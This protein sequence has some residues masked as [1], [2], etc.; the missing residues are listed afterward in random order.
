MSPRPRDV[1]TPEQI[2]TATMRR[3]QETPG[4]MHPE[5]AAKQLLADL[6]GHR[7]ELV[8][9]PAAPDPCQL[10]PATKLTA[11]GYCPICGP[12]D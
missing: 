2:L 10:H 6:A 9:R 1:L 4:P 5:L 11:H 12:K 3:I 8:H 7:Y